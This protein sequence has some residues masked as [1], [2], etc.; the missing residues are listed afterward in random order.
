MVNSRYIVRVIERLVEGQ[1]KEILPLEVQQVQG[2]DH[3]LQN[4]EQIDG[5]MELGGVVLGYLVQIP[6]PVHHGLLLVLHHGLQEQTERS[7]GCP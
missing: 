3:H 7:Q 2:M 5:Q 6:T 4:L 1:V